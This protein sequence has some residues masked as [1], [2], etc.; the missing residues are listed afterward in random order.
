M[1]SVIWSQEKKNPYHGL[2][3]KQV[4]STYSRSRERKQTTCEQ[5]PA[6]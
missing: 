1:Y 5:L 6:Y 3:S 2:D 4:Y